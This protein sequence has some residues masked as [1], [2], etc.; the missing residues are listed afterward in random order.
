MSAAAS[1]PGGRR[2]CLVNPNS[3]AEATGRMVAIARSTAPEWMTIEGRTTLAS[4]RLIVDD[5]GSLAAARAVVEDAAD[6]VDYGDGVILSAFIDPGIDRLR[7]RLSVPVV[8]IGESA[9]AEAAALGRFAVVMTTPA[10]TDALRHY[11]TSLGLIGKLVSVPGTAEEPHA[12]MAVPE[13]VVAALDS[14]IRRAVED[15][16]AEAVVVGGGPLADAARELA[17]IS[18]VPLIQAVP[19]AV[20]RMT[21]ILAAEA[22]S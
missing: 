7:E 13:R 22:V 15:D 10:L 20:R 8:G 5:A 1:G 21:A 17:P 14:L 16:G 2:V 3:N 6:G 19:A 11:V 18:P 9:L 12:L 4:P